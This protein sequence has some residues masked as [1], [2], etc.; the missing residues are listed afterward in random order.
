V[1]T[2][3][4][5]RTRHHSIY[6]GLKKLKNIEYVF[7]HDGV[8]P[9]VT[10]RIMIDLYNMLDS[11][12]NI[13]VIPVL[14]VKDTLKKIKDGFIEGTLDRK[15]IVA[16]QTPQAFPF[17]KIMEA[18]SRFENELEEFTDDAAIYEKAGYK[19]K[20][21]KGDYRNIKITTNEDLQMCEFIK[22]KM[23]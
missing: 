23:R 12:N 18:Y 19:V 17:E 2:V 9:L 7:I 13:G 8:R 3:A 15:D 1:A 10:G 4:G 11:D 22:T 14:P 21:V 6:N 20:T 5:G 16:V